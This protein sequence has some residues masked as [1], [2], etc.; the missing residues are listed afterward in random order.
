M[1]FWLVFAIS[2]FAIGQVN[3]D[4]K[5][6]LQIDTLQLS[7]KNYQDSTK[8]K[9]YLD[10]IFDHFRTDIGNSIALCD[11]L[12]NR[13]KETKKPSLMASARNIKG[14]IYAL[15]NDFQNAS[16]YYLE[17][18]EM[19]EKINKPYSTAMIYNNLGLM[20]NNTNNKK[21]ALQY[22]EKGL[23]IAEQH[24]VEKA[25]ALIYIN[26]TNLHVTEGNLKSGLETSL[27]ADAL[28]Q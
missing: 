2:S 11:Y 20:Y 13:S 15:K 16:K 25:K 19:F 22:L 4:Q 5:F 1:L 24:N 10:Y 17:A 14:S 23:K 7:K 28:C 12:Y 26:L 27:K 8:I 21:L 6:S 9:N 18:A 3:N